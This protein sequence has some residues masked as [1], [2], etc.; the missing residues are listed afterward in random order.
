MRINR[1]KQ[2]PF[3]LVKG[4]FLRNFAKI[5]NFTI[6]KSQTPTATSLCCVILFTKSILISAIKSQDYQLPT[7]THKVI[8]FLSPDS[9]TKHDTKPQQ[10]TCLSRRHCQVALKQPGLCQK[11]EN[12]STISD[13]FTN[14]IE[15]KV[16]MIFKIL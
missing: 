5:Q 4:S 2:H 7:S 6:I 9:I 3:F 12:Q 14:Q 10:A 15:R 1:H 8:L 13:L 16:E 11:P